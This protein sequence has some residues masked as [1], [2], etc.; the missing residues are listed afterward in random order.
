MARPKV[1]ADPNVQ[2]PLS[3]A[4]LGR[5]LWAGYLRAGFTRMSF[6]RA[7]GVTYATIDRWDLGESTPDLLLLMKAAV[8]IKMSLDDLCFGR[9]HPAHNERERTLERTDVIAT[10]DQLEASS[11]ARAAFG[12]FWRSPEGELQ[13]VTRTYL[14]TFVRALQAQSQRDGRDGAMSRDAIRRAAIEA[15][16]ARAQ[17]DTV[18]ARVKPWATASSDKASNKRRSQR[19]A[20]KT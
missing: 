18:S 5:R 10:L 20:K 3:E 16:R 4:S 7:M 9:E 15:D 6:S 1:R 13:R 11:E 8:L 14:T 2:D 19:I 17:A 12:R